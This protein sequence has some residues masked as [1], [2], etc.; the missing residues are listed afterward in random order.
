MYSLFFLG[1]V[2]LSNLG[3]A[4]E[5]L[6]ERNA[7]E[8][9]EQ[10]LAT[11]L[12]QNPSLVFENQLWCYLHFQEVPS[13]N[14]KASLSAA[15]IS[16]YQYQPNLKWF[17][18]MQTDINASILISASVDRVFTK[19][20]FRKMDQRIFRDE[21]PSHATEAHGVKANIVVAAESD[22][23]SMVTTLVEMGIQINDRLDPLGILNVSGSRQ[24]LLAAARMP[25]VVYVELPAPPAELEIE[26]EMTMTRAPYINGYYNLNG[27]NG[28]GVKIAVNE[29][30]IINP[31]YHP[32]FKNRLDLSEEG[33]TISGHKTGVSWRMASAGNINPI[34]R[35]QAW[36]A[37]QMSGGINFS[38]AA[39]S[40]INIVNN[41][42]ARIMVRD[43][44]GETSPDW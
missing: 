22:L 20:I 30:G 44:A 9:L 35:G 13:E 33:G 36:G 16:L 37:E 28:D 2:S 24:A 29:G 8:P 18:S 10:Q 15:G 12:T 27:L 17:A 11:L 3:Y 32:D 14:Q 6:P 19:P 34:H 5:S 4:Q 39:D 21:I 42:F 25:F 26:D 1:L 31:A 7:Q 40:N 38:N 41:S 23:S 43:Q